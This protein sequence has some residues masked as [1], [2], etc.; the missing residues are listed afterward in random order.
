M[1]RVQLDE[2]PDSDF[3]PIHFQMGYMLQGAT[4]FNQ[5]LCHFGDNTSQLSDASLMFDNSGCSNTNDPASATGPWC[6]VTTCP[7]SSQ[8]GIDNER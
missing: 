2:K 6:V 3:V 8:Q 7:Q 1:S 4:A 5:N